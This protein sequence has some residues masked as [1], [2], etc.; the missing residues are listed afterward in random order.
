MLVWLAFTL[1]A[2][3]AIAQTTTTYSNTTAGTINAATTCTAPL[4]RNFTVGASHIV[5]DVDL[6]LLATHSWR[7]DLRVTLQSPAGTRIQL[8]DGDT[9]S[10]DGNNFNVRL[11]DDTAQ[12]VNTDGNGT[13]HSTSAPPYQNGFRPNAPL[14]AF[15]GQNSAGTWRLEICD[16]Y[17][18]A[19]NGNFVRADLYLT[20]LPTNY[21]DLSLTK[22]VSNAA[23]AFGASLNY[24]LS[25]TNAS[26]SPL[27]ATGV[28]VQDT[29]PAGFNFTGA[30]GFGSYNSATGVWSV[31]SIPPGVTRVLT[32]SGTVAATAGAS[33]TNSAEISAS[34]AF[35]F[36]STPGN[37]AAGEDDSDSASFTV[38][39]TRVAGT[40]PAL[41]CPVGTT[42]LDWDGVGWPA[43]TTSRSQALTAIG[44]ANVNIA[45]SGGSFLS[46]ATYGGQSPTRQNVVAGG[47]A[48]AQ[49]SIFE[50]VD[51][52]SQAGTVTSTIALPTAVPGAQFRL[53]DVDYASGQFADRVTVT[54]TYNGATVYP[55][56][57]N[58]TANY[59]IGNSAYGDIL[60]ADGSADGSVT[61]TF[62]TPI[63]GIAIEYGSHALAP[64]NPGQQGMALHD[65]IFCR[66][67]TNLAIGKTS[68]IVS[69]PV[70]GTANPKAIP[71]ARMRYCILVTNN[72]SGTATGINLADPLPAG[73]SFV[74]GSLRSGTSCAGAATAEDDNASG[75]DEG[76]PFGASI[77]GA[78]VAAT[79]ATL[80]PA[81][82]MAITFEIT[83]N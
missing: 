31:G 20:S 62:D 33:V 68:S 44:T 77:T 8:V 71:G 50:I 40:P 1:A 63:D 22:S 59:V 6:G 27:T 79:T 65:I 76:D 39:G 25:V 82:A 58:G 47:L 51:F 23:P 69:D 43:G 9:G 16:Q 64:A 13:N 29:L 14:S 54:G 38:S 30:S 3:P 81:A 12:T 34:S 73:T 56:L 10:I 4:V 72:G 74:P 28:T 78:T 11:D 80:L 37:G 70:N 49:Y 21:A 53:F 24:V 52:T 67:T 18:S 32:I 17:P 2:N 41:V 45:I 83:I 75:A 36:D 46:N 42:V 48:P 19:D 26:G 55:V 61:V 66:P 7:G 57:T 35:D 5:G 60:S 15:N